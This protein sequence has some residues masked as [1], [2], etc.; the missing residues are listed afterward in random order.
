MKSF[1]IS[2]RENKFDLHISFLYYEIFYTIFA[3]NEFNS[4]IN[5]YHFLNAIEG[6]N[7]TDAKSFPLIRAKK[8]NYDLLL[9]YLQYLQIFTR[10]IM[11]L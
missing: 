5:M 9:L 7:L 3:R 4:R 1:R 8:I 11:Y 6:I 2:K 10:Y